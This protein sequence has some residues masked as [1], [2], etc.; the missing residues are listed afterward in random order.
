MPTSQLVEI[1]G[2]HR[3][4]VMLFIRH[5]ESRYDALIC[6]EVLQDLFAPL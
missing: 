4:S 5:K 1:Y 3:E 6:F 2:C